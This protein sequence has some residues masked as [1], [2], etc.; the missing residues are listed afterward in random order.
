MA[1]QSVACF[2]H[3]GYCGGGINA[4]RKME[5]ATAKSMFDQSRPL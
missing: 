1:T 5:I 4:K 2:C 3:H